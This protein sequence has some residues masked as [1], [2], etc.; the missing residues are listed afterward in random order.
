MQIQN[1]PTWEVQQSQEGII[2]E[3]EYE[4]ED[5]SQGLCSFC[6]HETWHCSHGG[7]G[8]SWE[9]FH[10]WETKFGKSREMTAKN[11]KLILQ[12]IPENAGIPN[13]MPTIDLEEEAW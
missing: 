5:T 4:R 13:E 9:E 11:R 1:K 8:F 2:A 3:A 12:F 6:G 10:E 7:H